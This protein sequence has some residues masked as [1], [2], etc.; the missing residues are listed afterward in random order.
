MKVGHVL[1]DTH[2][3][4]YRL[5]MEIILL[6]IIGRTSRT[7]GTCSRRKTVFSESFLFEVSKE[8]SI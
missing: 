3:L 1:F 8:I 6:I 4:S 5:L 2:S 7:D